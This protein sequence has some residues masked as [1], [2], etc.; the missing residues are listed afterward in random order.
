MAVIKK[1]IIPSPGARGVSQ[2]QYNDLVSWLGFRQTILAH[3]FESVV[4]TWDFW[5]SANQYLA[6]GLKNTS[7]NQNDLVNC[8]HCNWRVYVTGLCNC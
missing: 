7:G 4:G 2:T 3:D 5:T 6:G 8:F 1:K